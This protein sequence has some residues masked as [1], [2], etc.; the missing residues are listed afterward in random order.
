MFVI[1]FAASVNSQMSL[2]PHQQ[3]V[4]PNIPEYFF[5]S[6]NA[7]SSNNTIPLIP[8]QPNT[9]FYAVPPLLSAVPK[10]GSTVLTLEFC[11]GTP[12]LQNQSVHVFDFIYATQDMLL[13]NITGKMDVRSR[14]QTQICSSVK[15]NYVCC[16]RVTLSRS[17]F[18]LSSS[19]L[20]YGLL[21]SDLFPRP[22]ALEN[23]GTDLEVE[24]FAI[25]MPTQQK[26]GIVVATKR[27][28]SSLPLL[29]LSLGT[30]SDRLLAMGRCM[31]SY[32]WVCG[33][34]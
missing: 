7:S 24:Q 17:G 31:H 3:V 23:V 16:D 4:S 22:L 1:D 6:T 33:M 15:S 27:M 5:N 8:A 9:Y 28:T 12:H 20:A 30:Y 11:Y 18:E 14:P 25:H 26:C 10:C 13:F 19:H 29:R 21:I 32:F 2:C 34:M